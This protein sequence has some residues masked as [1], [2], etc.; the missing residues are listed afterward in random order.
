MNIIFIRH[1]EPNYELDT[2]TKKGWKEAEL[3]AKRVS[4]WNVKDFYCSP[5]GRAQD[6]ASL[7][8]KAMN[9]TA[10]TYEWLKEFYYPV[11]DPVT[12][13]FGTPW[14]FMPEFFTYEDQLYDRKKWYE[15][16]VFAEN[17]GLAPAY[18]EVCKEFDKLLEKYGYFR[19]DDYYEAKVH[20]DDTIVIFCHLGV[21]M[22]IM[23]YLCGI[24]PSILWQSFFM[25]PSSVTIL[26][27]EERIPPK[28]F[29][30]CQV[31]GDTTHLHDG[32]EPI[33]SAGF[34]TEVYQ[35]L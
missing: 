17:R 35:E 22:L 24:S 27:S 14:D 25:A 31:L 3:L 33:S 16:P 21:S 5:L 1:A 19:K 7:T 30:R 6:T 12:N 15:A 34:F 26:C 8:L 10:T 11:H 32:K 23:G 18:K 13:D 4:K 2:L 9:R 28:A 20:N 29:F